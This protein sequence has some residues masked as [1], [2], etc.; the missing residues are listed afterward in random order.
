MKKLALVVVFVSNP[1]N[2]LLSASY[3]KI[4]GDGA[5]GYDFNSGYRISEGYAK[6]A[7][8]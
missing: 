4:H 3:E 1:S 6:L 7:K 2:V 8:K 5:M